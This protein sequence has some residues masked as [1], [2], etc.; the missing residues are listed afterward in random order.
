MKKKSCVSLLLTLVMLLTLAV[1]AGVSA[2]ADGTAAK[3]A[4]Q[5]KLIS[6]QTGNLMQTNT[7]LPWYYT[8]TDLDHDGCLEFIAASQHP[9]DRSTNLKV[10]EVSK[11][12]TSLNEC[13]L[14]KDEDES[15]PDIMTDTVDTYHVKDTDTW[16]YMVYDNVVISDNE[17]YTVKTAID[18]KNDVIGYDA[19]ALEHTVVT[20]GAKNVSHMDVNGLPISAEQYNAAGNNAFVGADRS[21]TAFEWLTADKIGNQETLTESY[22]V[23]IGSREPTEVF[24]VPKPVALGGTGVAPTPTP[25]PVPQPQPQPK[26]QPQPVQPTYLTITKN[27]TNENRKVGGNAIFVACANAY[28]SLNWTFVSPDGGEYSPAS[29]VSGSGAYVTGE[30][31]TTITVNKL[32]SWM[33]GWGAYC[34]F[35]FQGQTARTSTAYIYVSGGTPT[36]TPT[37]T[38][39]YGSMSGTA[40]E[41][42][43][44]Y[45]IYLQNGT[46][47]FVDS[48]KCKVEGQFYD[49][50]S[51]IVYYT[52]YP[53]SNNIYQV[54]IWG[55]QGLIPDPQPTYGS[56][57]GT[58]HEGGG[59]YAINLSNGTQVYVDGWKCNVTGQFYDGASAVVYYTDYP[60]S[61]NIYSVDIFGNQGLIVSGYTTANDGTVY[62]IHD[63]YNNDGSTYNTVT[64]PNCGNQVSMAEDACPYCHYDIWGNGSG[65]GWAGSNYNDDGG[66]AGSNYYDDNLIGDP[67]YGYYD[68]YGEWRFY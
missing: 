51:A 17:V 46:Q 18:L 7:E 9:D 42:G 68:D 36:P 1:G 52:D 66:W 55:N 49:G 3:P 28:D 12:G 57:S 45:A 59:G 26:P 15:F 20:N 14:D 19:Y 67:D 41:G 54:D 37:P 56:M 40:Y 10:W 61:D 6:S 11:D 48:W 60:S 22:E 32:E 62:E 29:F 25:T 64:C 24:P 44:G 50:C 5:L 63:A 53:S 38:P 4:Q 47:V 34:S 58:A 43:A 13:R 2:Y 33:N 16:Y 65:G 35:Y 27:P 8:V 31:S 23:F 39:G 30:Y 21:N